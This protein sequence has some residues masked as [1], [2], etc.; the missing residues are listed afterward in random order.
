MKTDDLNTWKKWKVIT[1]DDEFFIEA[2]DIFVV[3]MLLFDNEY[4]PENIKSI[5]LEE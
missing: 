4:E 3:T 1:N 5:T 2:P